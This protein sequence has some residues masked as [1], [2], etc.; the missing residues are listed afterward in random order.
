V[1]KA[2]YQRARAMRHNYPRTRCRLPEQEQFSIASEAIRASF[3]KS[4]F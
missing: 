4:V 2:A 3:Q 1:D